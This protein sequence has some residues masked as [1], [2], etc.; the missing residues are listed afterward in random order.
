MTKTSLTALALAALIC[1][2]LP[3]QSFAQEKKDEPKKDQPAKEAPKPDDTKKEEPKKEEPKKDPKAS[4]YEKAV[5]ELKRIDGPWTL[6]QRKK[7]LLLEL[8]EDKVGKVFL[9]QAALGSSLDGGF[10]H[11]GMPFGGDNIDAFRFDKQDD[12]V[13]LV[14]PRI[15]VRWDKNDPFSVGA[16][17]TFQEG[18]L[19]TFPIE[20][21]NPEK[22]LL[23][24]NVTELFYGDVFR[25]SEMVSQM[26]GGAYALDRSKSGVDKVNGFPG[27]TTVSMKMYYFSPRGSSGSSALLQALGI[28]APN[29]LEDD[30]SAPL[31]VVYNAWFRDENNGYQPRLADPRVGYFTTDSTTFDR[32]SE[33]D[34]KQS[35]IN[36]FQLQKKDPKA[37]VSEPV[38]PIVWT[39]DPSIPAE[40]RE[41]IR[42]GILYWNKAF[43]AI[44]YKNAVQVQDPPKDDPNYDHADG[45]YN[46]VRMSPSLGS[47][48]AAIA[49]ARSDPYTGQTYNAS[50]TIDGGVVRDLLT[51][52]AYY[53]PTPGV[54]TRQHQLDVLLRNSTRK[55]TDEQYLYTPERSE[56]EM[57]LDESMGKFGWK[58]YE[59]TYASDLAAEAALDWYAIEQSPAGSRVSRSDFVKKYLEDCVCHEVG[60]T[61]GLRHNFAGSTALTTAE[62]ADDT[63]TNK[64]G[65]SASVMDYTPPNALAVLKG[66]GN[67]FNTTV[68]TYDEWAI[69][70]G[71]ADFGK[72][73]L[74]EKFDL[75]Q[76]AKLSGVNGN[77]YMTDEDADRWNPYAVRFDLAKDPL[78]Y[79]EKALVAYK[80]ALKYALTNLPR[81]GEPYSKRT[82]VVMSAIS[83][84]FREGRAAARFVGGIASTRNFRGDSGEKPTL[85]PVSPADQRKAMSLIVQHFLQADSVTLPSDVLNTMT[86][87]PDSTGW[88]APLRDYIGTQQSNLVALMMSATTTDRIA[89]NAYKAGANAY[90]VDEH[91]GALI[92]ASFSE[93]GSSNVTPL[94][95]DLQ[96]FVLRA[97]MLQAGAPSGG[98][99]EDVRTVA[100]DCLRRLANRFDAALKTKSTLD[101]MTRVHLS[102][103]A[104]QI[105]RFLNRQYAE[106]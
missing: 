30:R 67:F 80:R 101:G 69:K 85:A 6:Y 94:R 7:E 12:K 13:W 59:C 92:G 22:H 46:V 70:Y 44:G 2:G 89:E 43:E 60:H 82:E 37:K 55:L 79:S 71:Y 15:G 86:M 56:A 11:A 20:Q 96:K 58:R 78:N 93:V 14:R 77:A 57:K 97:L 87:M 18:V 21:T 1:G 4:D 23:L 51:M 103:S 24:I 73:S 5:K 10:L 100:F 45:R 84:S 39:I 81:P 88:T 25:L 9:I 53:L 62:L 83:R 64:V 72:S 31:R 17:R 75:S 52:H 90:N 95:R 54:N 40:Y 35:F 68:G 33:A 105:H 8:P 104:D 76:I 63:L 91:Y 27:N 66:N 26:L 74:G 98:I 34:P 41:S 28:G 38:K 19:G 29:T 106:R 99:N 42:K 48:F 36:R 32:Y 47:P 16:E 49:L 3:T 50:V 102:D 61:L 65:V